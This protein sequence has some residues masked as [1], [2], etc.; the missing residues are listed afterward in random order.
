MYVSLSL[1]SS[2]G[3]RAG[4]EI[5][6]LNGTSVTSLDLGLM[7]AYF[8]QQSVSLVVWR[9]EAVS[10]DQSSLWPDCD[11]SESRRPVP[12]PEQV[13]HME[14]FPPWSSGNTLPL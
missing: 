8:S 2:A 14:H 13:H 3:L 5:L 7:Q 4:D 9:E 10:D 6:V 12:P 1:R 11:S